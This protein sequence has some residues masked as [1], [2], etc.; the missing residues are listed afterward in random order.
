M[1]MDTAAHNPGQRATPGSCRLGVRQDMS[2]R[3]HDLPGEWPAQWLV[4]SEHST[5]PHRFRAEQRSGVEET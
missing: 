3:L 1:H 5:D 2:A 4:Q